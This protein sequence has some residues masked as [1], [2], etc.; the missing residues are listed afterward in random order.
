M[1]AHIAAVNAGIK[2]PALKMI[3][4]LQTNW[5]EVITI[6]QLLNPDNLLLTKYHFQ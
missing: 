1:P 4:P 6:A 5:V 3:Q 2:N